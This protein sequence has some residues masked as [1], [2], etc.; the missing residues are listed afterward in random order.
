MTQNQ[1]NVGSPQEASLSVVAVVVCV[2][3]NEAKLIFIQYPA[4]VPR[5]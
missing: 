3:M 2:R 4:R 5:N 1:F